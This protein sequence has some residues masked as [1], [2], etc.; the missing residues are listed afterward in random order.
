MD[1]QNFD[2]PEHLAK[3]RGLEAQDY[4]PNNYPTRT[5]LHM[6]HHN[7]ELVE[8]EE[9]KVQGTLGNEEICMICEEEGGEEKELFSCD[10]Q[11]SEEMEDGRLMALEERPFRACNSK[12]HLECIMKSLDNRSTP[13]KAFRRV[14]STFKQSAHHLSSKRPLQS[15]DNQSSLDQ[16]KPPSH[17]QFW[18][19]WRFISFLRHLIYK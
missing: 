14:R 11:I 16:Q 18:I 10:D 6:R 1:A 19:K 4:D 7:L 9:G 8:D 3:I 13:L 5:S 2:T 17:Y 12:F 15:H